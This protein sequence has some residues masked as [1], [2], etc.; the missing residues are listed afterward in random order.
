M[1]KENKEV[2]H[3]KKKN[4][5]AAKTQMKGKTKIQIK[6]KHYIHC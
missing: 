6:R 2:L 5:Q 3:G 1:G 4:I